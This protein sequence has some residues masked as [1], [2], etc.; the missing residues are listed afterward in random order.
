M[1]YRYRVLALL[2]L[3]AIITYLDRVC[4]SVAGPR[5]QE[6]LN[7]SPVSWGWVVGAFFLSYSL[8]AIPS[9]Y[10]GDRIG[11]RRV[12]TRIVLWWSVFTSLTGM[13][14]NY[15]FLLLTRFCFGAGEAGAI[16]NAAIS[17]SRWFPLS[18]RGRV[19]GIMWMA[20]HLGGALSP[21]LVVPIQMRYGWRASFYLFG[22]FGVLWSMV[23]YRWYRDT[24]AEK[25]KVTTA[26]INEIGA[27][28]SKPSHSLPWGVALRSKNLWMLMLTC[29]CGA[30]GAFFFSTWLHTYLVRSRGFSEIDLLLST[31][32]FLLAAGANIGGGI[33]SDVLAMKF[34]LK[35]G[36]RAVGIIGLTSAALFT[37]AALLTM[38]KYLVLVFLGLAY[39]G[40]AFQVPIAFAVGIDVGKKYAGSVTGAMNTAGTAGGFLMS[41]SFGYQ[42]KVT[43]SY[44]LPL[45]PMALMLAIAASL[46]LQI[47]ATQELIPESQIELNRKAAQPALG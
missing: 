9:G 39:A 17:I 40:M 28:A 31:F 23:W 3:L 18:E 27:L 41:V 8:F 19:L 24:P 47:D 21:L 25:L 46:W 44:D 42:V 32:P 2:F 10:M 45:I 15:A 5:M 26:E 12:L 11:P 29:F 35:R 6:S 33:T 34:G 37:I 38:N 36:R 22:G 7:I 13:V 30:Y 43:G 16:P 4:I 14:S 1:K 20:G